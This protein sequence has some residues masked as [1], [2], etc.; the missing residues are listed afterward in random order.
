MSTFEN[1]LIPGRH[2]L[3]TNFQYEYLKNLLSDGQSLD[4]NGQPIKLRPSPN[5]IWAVTSANHENTRR[6]PIPSNRR[7]QAIET[8]CEE[9]P[10]TSFSYP[11]NDLGYTQ[12]F[13]DFVIKEITVQSRGQFNISPSNTLVLCSTPSVID[14]YEKLG[15]VIAPAELTNRQ[16]AEASHK[17]PWD[18][19]LAIVAAG[20]SWRND[21][22]YQ[23]DV[24]YS[25]RQ[26]LEKYR[27]GDLILEVF[28][29]P[30]LGDEG[31]I[32]ETRDYETYRRDFEVGAERKFE[33]IKPFIKSGRVVDIGCATGGV[34]QLM[35]RDPKLAESDLY[36]IEASRKLYDI[37][38]QRRKNGEFSNDNV[39]FY[40]RNIMTGM[41]FPD[42]SI[43]TTT[44]FSL[45]HEIESYLGRDA[46]LQFIK[47]IYAQ[48]AS[49]GVFIN[50]DVV[51]PDNKD[52][53]VLLK[54]NNSNGR[55]ENW[56]EIDVSPKVDTEH[57]KELSTLG[58]FRRFSRDFRAEEQQKFEFKQVQDNGSEYIEL[59]LAD[60]C[61]FLSKKDYTDS[62]YS[63]MHETFC[64]WNYEQWCQAVKQVGFSVMDGSNA[65]TND[66]VIENRY[67][68]GAQLFVRGDD[69]LKPLDFPV[70][71]MLLI[72][73]KTA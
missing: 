8:F 11:I 31:D 1:I 7:E 26:M 49:G 13:A 24:H 42:N 39:F 20:A 35:S 58:R 48:T 57:I 50:S 23:S 67:K 70:T 44:T 3:L 32:T 46:L 54:L 2:H 25:S 22:L 19:V 14:M 34:I 18:L 53:L 10:A 59:R 56:E 64:Y 5:I 65:Y 68:D 43:D 38:E 71:N 30:L 29:D 9:L 63:E 47:K 61:E 4:I 72:A 69:G 40:Q 12:R 60:A 66:W 17:R 45:T 52:Q 36:G 16:T 33:L 55:T 27:L 37:C 62:W 28:N 41:I 73:E 51:A 15:Y 6:N 21:P